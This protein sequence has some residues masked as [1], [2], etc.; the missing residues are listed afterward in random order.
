MYATK[1][2]Q[3]TDNTPIA[4]SVAE[5]VSYESMVENGGCRRLL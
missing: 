1:K 5:F 4:S 3:L 2:T